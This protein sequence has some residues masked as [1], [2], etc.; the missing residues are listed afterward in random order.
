MS[1]Q[2]HE[3]S[4]LQV[5]NELGHAREPKGDGEQ[6]IMSRYKAIY[7]E[8]SNRLKEALSR[9]LECN[10]NLEKVAALQECVEC[11]EQL[12]LSKS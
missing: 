1:F 6:D 8:E 2:Q 7:N 3:Y 4:R 11:E 12:L 9:Y 10:R 5:F